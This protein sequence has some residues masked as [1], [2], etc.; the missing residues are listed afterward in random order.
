MLLRQMPRDARLTFVG[1]FLVAAADDSAVLVRRMAIPSPRI[2]R[3]SGVC[4]APFKVSDESGYDLK[5]VK[6]SA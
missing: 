4:R 3:R 5:K 1:I 2:N 6:A